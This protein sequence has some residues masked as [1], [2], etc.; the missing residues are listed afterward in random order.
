MRQHFGC[1]TPHWTADTVIAALRAAGLARGRGF[2]IAEWE[3]ARTR[4]SVQQVYR[5]CGSWAD[6]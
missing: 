4:P 1:R 2:T 6:A 3:R 5:V